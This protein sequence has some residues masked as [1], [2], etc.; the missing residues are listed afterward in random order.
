MKKFSIVWI[1]VMFVFSISLSAQELTQSIK[2]QV[3]EIHT[4]NPVAF[5]NVI[6]T[7]QSSQHG[8]LSDQEGYFKIINVAVGRQNLSFSLMG[9]KSVQLENIELLSGK[10]LFVSIEMEEEILKIE[11]VS[12]KGQKKKDQP[13]NDMAFLSSRSFTVEETERYAGSG[14]DPARMVQNF[15]GV[16]SAGDRRNDNR[17]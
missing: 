12:I 6:V 4:G 13:L 7:N 2:G 11:E 14:G 9:Y 15:A 17:N 10:E 8:T 1:G 5:A 3:V 16:S